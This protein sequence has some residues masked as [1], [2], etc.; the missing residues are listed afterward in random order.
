MCE[1]LISLVVFFTGSRGKS[2]WSL[3]TFCISGWRTSHLVKTAKYGPSI[4]R[5]CDVF[6]RP[7][8]HRSTL[9]FH[10]GKNYEPA[11]N[12]CLPLLSGHK[13]KRTANI[14]TKNRSQKLIL[15]LLER[16]IALLSWDRENAAASPYFTIW[17]IFAVHW[18]NG[19]IFHKLLSDKIMQPESHVV[20][21]R[22][23]SP[24]LKALGTHNYNTLHTT[25]DLACDKRERMRK[26][27]LFVQVVALTLHRLRTLIKAPSF[28]FH[29][30][31]GFSVSFSQNFKQTHRP[32]E[33]FFSYKVVGFVHRWGH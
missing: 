13:C 4:R 2:A 6:V 20:A 7:Y 33:N 17:H 16:A 31:S 3:G 19:N 1:Y 30:W 12:A 29:W 24:L 21:K 26:K 9:L 23:Q 5:I 14:Y 25:W 32:A 22:Q 11:R 15:P 28:P 18:Y 8:G 10:R 27:I